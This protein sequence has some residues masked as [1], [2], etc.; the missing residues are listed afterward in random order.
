M[1]ELA[2]LLFDDDDKATAEAQRDSPVAPV[3]PSLSAQDKART[4]RMPEDFPVH[5]F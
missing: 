5:R 1:L 2:P 3:K 4:L